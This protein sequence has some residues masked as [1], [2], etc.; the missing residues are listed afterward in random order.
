MQ[1]KECNHIYS[2][3]DICDVSLVFYKKG[4][5]FFVLL[6]NPLKNDYLEDNLL[7]KMLN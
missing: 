7:L 4:E 5:K 6:I 2:F 1:I 3:N